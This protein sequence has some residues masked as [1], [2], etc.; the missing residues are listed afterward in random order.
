VIE[1]GADSELATA[2]T[3]RGYEDAIERFMLFDVQG[4]S[5]NC[6]QYITP[7]A[8]F[9]EVDAA[10]TPLLNRIKDLETRLAKYETVEPLQIIER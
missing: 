3:P 8:T 7:R 9:A 5:W 6:S 4:F 2:L 1:K 10:L